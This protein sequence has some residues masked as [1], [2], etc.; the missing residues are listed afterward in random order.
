MDITGGGAEDGLRLL[1][2]RRGR[3]RRRRATH[4]GPGAHHVGAASR[5]RFPCSAP[6]NGAS[7]ARDAGHVLVKVRWSF[8][9]Q[10]HSQSQNKQQHQGPIL[11]LFILVLYLTGPVHVSD[12]CTRQHA[13]TC[14]ET[15]HN[16][17]YI[18]HLEQLRVLKH[19][20]PFLCNNRKSLISVLLDS[21]CKLDNMFDQLMFV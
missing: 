6:W 9:L 18:T 14:N 8:R 11:S 19:S 16:Y 17:T 3:R 5:L 13:I 21:R 10:S 12:C 15:R 4:P 7:S 1:G 2:F 20:R